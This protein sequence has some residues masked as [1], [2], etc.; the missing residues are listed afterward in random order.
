MSDDEDVLLQRPL[1]R[2]LVERKRA[3]AVRSA[4]EAAKENCT[5]KTIYDLIYTI[6]LSNSL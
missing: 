2:N 5:E 6:G 4:E 3:I 1:P